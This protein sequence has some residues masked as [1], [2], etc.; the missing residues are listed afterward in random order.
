[1]DP[2]RHGENEKHQTHVDYYFFPVIGFG[3]LLI[4]VCNKSLCLFSFVWAETQT[5]LLTNSPEGQETS[6]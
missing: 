2:D 1:M 6:K 5:V 4:S 3:S